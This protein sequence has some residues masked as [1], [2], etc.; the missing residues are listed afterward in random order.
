[1]TNEPDFIKRLNAGLDQSKISTDASLIV[2]FS[3]GPDSSALLSGLSKL[4]SKRRLSL[5][6][7]HVNHQIRPAHSLNDQTKAKEIAKELNVEFIDVKVDVPAFAAT[8]RLSIESAARKLRYKALCDVAT[9]RNADAIATGHTSDDQ[10]ETVLMHAAR[11]AGLNG[12]SGMRF[13]GTLK[14]TEP[15]VKIKVVRP[16]LDIR[17]YMCLEFCEKQNIDPVFDE[18][19]MSRK[20]TR[21]RLRLD[22]LPYL[23]NA[24][25]GST[26][27]L[28]RLAKNIASD[29]SMIDWVTDGYLREATVESNTYSRNS[30]RT[31]PSFL[32]SRIIMKAYEKRLGHSNGLERKHVGKMVELLKNDSGNS[33]H[34]PNKMMFFIDKKTF[35]FRAI[36][37][38]DCPYPHLNKP[39]KITIPGVLKLGQNVSFI[40]RIIERPLKLNRDGNE[41]TFATPELIYESLQLRHRLNGDRIQPMGMKN[42]VK[43][44]DLLVNA[45]VPERWRERIPLVDSSKGLVWIP[46]HRLADW[47]KVRP[48][49]SKVLRLELTGVKQYSQEKD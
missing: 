30:I 49:H 6:A 11:G 3:G 16:M 4:K 26:E 7:V 28:S 2:A 32:I 23:E 34:L 10:A 42:T 47:A 20:H 21:N 44:Q 22:V 48:E 36:D 43:L 31:L 39:R 41:I 37:E 24:M 12:L 15:S 29:L 18:S 27:A 1:M 14:I 46:G 13:T 17:R 25:P 45:G 5:I 19:N 33:I 35:G 38:D 8:Q 40:S 9:K